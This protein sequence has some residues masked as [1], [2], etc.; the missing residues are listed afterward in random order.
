MTAFPIH[1]R[2]E[3]AL[4]RRILARVLSRRAL[5]ALLAGRRT[6]RD[7]RTLDPQ[8]AAVL[9]L[10]RIDARNDLTGHDVASARLQLAAQIASADLPDPPPGVTT[11]AHGAAGPA[12]TIPLRLYT[13]EGAVA[14]APGVVFFHGGGWVT[15]SIATHDRFCRR[16]AAGARCRV[17]SVEYRL[18]PEHPFPAAVED[19][20]AAFRW[21]ARHAGELGMDA[22][23]LAVCG[24]SAGGNLSAVVSRHTRADAV[25][26]ALQVLIYPSV[27]ATRSLPSQADLSQ[28]YYLDDAL[29]NWFIDRYAGR[30]DR[31]HPDLAPLFQDLAGAPPALIYTAGFDPLRDEGRRY[32]ERLR[33]AGVAARHAEFPSLI[34]G[35]I[36]TGVID[37]ARLSIAEIIAD[38]GRSLREV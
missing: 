11:E 36:L 38:V 7:G 1:R 32:A 2:I 17:V 3:I 15:G 24:D 22:A 10:S 34:H 6:E 4:Q 19:A 31:A 26:P 8:T 9:R 29:I 28:G 18:A 37:A 13:P 35:F 30:C 12:G 16:L 27:D 25:R 33:E 21:V 23:R 20:V 14:P 5:V